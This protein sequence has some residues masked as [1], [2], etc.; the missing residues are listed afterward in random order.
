M[1]MV[2]QGYALS[3]FR[4][5]KDNGSPGGKDDTAAEQLG[6]AHTVALQVHHPEKHGRASNIS[7]CG[8]TLARAIADRSTND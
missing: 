8:R 5:R 6:A 3:W 1:F 4:K 7:V 2:R